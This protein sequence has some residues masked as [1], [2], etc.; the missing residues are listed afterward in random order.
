MHRFIIL[1]ALGACFTVGVYAC[2]GDSSGAD[3]GPDAGD[4][5]LGD[6]P[7]DS[8]DGQSDS[9]DADDGFTADDGNDGAITDDT[10]HSFDATATACPNCCKSVHATGAAVYSTAFT[11]CSCGVDG[12]CTSLCTGNYCLTANANTACATCQTSTCV[13]AANGACDADTNCV[14]YQNCKAGCP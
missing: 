4:A 5:T 2:N 7:N 12:G 9:S 8:A 13:P 1:G 3:A 10:C 14:A 11:A 6:S